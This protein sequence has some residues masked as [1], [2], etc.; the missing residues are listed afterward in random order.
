[1]K[2][3]DPCWLTR[4]RTRQH[5]SVRQPRKQRRCV[6]R[7]DAN[8]HRVAAW[9]YREPFSDSRREPPPPFVLAA[10]ER[11]LAADKVAPLP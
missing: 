8:E 5:F 2:F 4:P 10:V 6:L 1:V 3:L 9:L 7:L 11:A